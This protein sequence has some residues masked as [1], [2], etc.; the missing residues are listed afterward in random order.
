MSAAMPVAAPPLESGRRVSD[1]R[2]G[3]RPER[4]EVL[5]R[6]FHADRDAR[7]RAEL[8]R[9][10]QPLARRQVMRYASSRTARE[11]LEQVAYLG[12]LKA[13]D[14]YE[15]GHGT[16]FSSYAVPTI[17]GEL[18]RYFRD[19]GWCVHVPRGVQELT[20]AVRSATETLTAELRRAPSIPEIADRVGVPADS[21]FDAL[22][23]DGAYSATSLDA[24]TSDEEGATT[25]A[26]RHGSLD[27][28]Y[29]L[30][31]ERDAVSAAAR[32]LTQREREVIALRFAQEL[33]QTQIAERLGVS[34]MQVSRVLRR[35][36]SRLSTV[37]AHQSGERPAVPRPIEVSAS[38][39]L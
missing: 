12:L 13:I 24:P 1:R 29:E 20:V 23:A 21:V 14:G 16:A 36:L 5:L 18:R 19:T 39:L 9:V 26:E 33:T 30:V 35:A 17:V 32:A 25:L 8:V 2:A 3:T 22:D 7:D 31:D 28:G 38:P 15:P 6:R 27:G 37:A 34:Q 4:N 10:F 11:D